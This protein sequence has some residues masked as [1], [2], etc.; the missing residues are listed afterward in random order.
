MK[1]LH[2]QINGSKAFFDFTKGEDIEYRSFFGYC[3]A[4]VLN[5][6]ELG[7]DANKLGYGFIREINRV[8]NYDMF[9]AMLDHFNIDE[10]HEVFY[11]KMTNDDDDTERQSGWDD[12]EMDIIN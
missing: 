6:L 10:D 11:A 2:F 4:I 8:G 1:S 9:E 7:A 3:V 12:W 5:S